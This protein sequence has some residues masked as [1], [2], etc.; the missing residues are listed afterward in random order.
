MGSPYQY[1]QKCYRNAIGE[2]L[3][4]FFYSLSL[5]NLFGILFTTSLVCSV[6]YLDDKWKNPELVKWGW[7]NVGNALKSFYAKE[8]GPNLE[9]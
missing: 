7:D 5:P 6:M 9:N 4:E 8:A 3:S 1:L 2:C